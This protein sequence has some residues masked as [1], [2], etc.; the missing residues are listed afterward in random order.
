MK[1]ENI[2][3]TGVSILGRGAFLV[4]QAWRFKWVLRL[5]CAAIF[6]D[7][8]LILKTGHGLWQWN[9][10]NNSLLNDFGFIVISFVAFNL[11][12]AILLPVT[13]SILRLV[14]ASLLYDM[15][16]PILSRIPK[17]AGQPYRREIGKVPAYVLR[18]SAL[19][20]KDDFEYRLYT[21]HMQKKELDDELRN[22]TGDLVASVLLISVLDF[23]VS[24]LQSGSIGLIDGSYHAL[25]DFASIMAFF[26]VYSAGCIVKSAWYP[27]Y[28]PDTVYYPPLDKVLREKEKQAE[29]ERE[30]YTWRN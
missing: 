17:P 27:K 9:S 22:Q 7:I 8:A 16:V 5:T 2:D 23:F 1:Q 29:M 30:R 6:L 13:L 18:D 19:N 20:E 25:G 11:F 26:A 3:S 14:G 24:Y 12:S 21:E 28:K 4:E 10:D 15:I